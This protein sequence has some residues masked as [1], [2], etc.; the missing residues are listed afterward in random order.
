[1]PPSTPLIGSWP[2]VARLGPNNENILRVPEALAQL[3][4]TWQQWVDNVGGMF[5]AMEHEQPSRI[6]G[7]PECSI[8]KGLA[9][10][11]AAVQECTDD[12][13]AN[14]GPPDGA[15]KGKACAIGEETM[16]IDR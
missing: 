9:M 1:V 2:S 11:I 13:D 8:Y 14:I 10:D 16:D 15:V 12:S 3:I 5:E 6:Y 7:L 4:L